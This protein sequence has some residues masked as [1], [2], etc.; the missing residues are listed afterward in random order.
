M[1]R[2][3]IAAEATERVNAGTCCRVGERN[4]VPEWEYGCENKVIFVQSRLK[5]RRID[6]V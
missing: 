4:P 5:P 2:H 6:P 3:P 1:M